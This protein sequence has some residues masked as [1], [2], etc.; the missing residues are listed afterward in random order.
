MCEKESE[1][2]REGGR[3]ATKKSNVTAKQKVVKIGG[4]RES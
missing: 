2:M 4:A 3:S 1:G